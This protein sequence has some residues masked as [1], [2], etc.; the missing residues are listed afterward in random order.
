MYSPKLEPDLVRSLYRVKQVYTRPMT[1]LVEQYVMAGLQG[2]D[3]SLVCRICV[4]E[5]NNSCGDCYLAKI[6]EEERKSKRDN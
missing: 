1:E 6:K 5:R 2:V 3:K 4:G